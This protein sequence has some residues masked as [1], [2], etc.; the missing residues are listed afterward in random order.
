MC[1]VRNAPLAAPRKRR[2]AACNR[3]RLPLKPLLTASHD[4]AFS[5]Y[6]QSSVRSTAGSTSSVEVVPREVG[7]A[8]REE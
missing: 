1:D 8:R 6:D 5:S 7:F 3:T 2:L 4:G